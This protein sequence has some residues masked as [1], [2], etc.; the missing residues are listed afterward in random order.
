VELVV[1]AD[2]GFADPNLFAALER[3]GFFYIV[4]LR[5]NARLLCKVERIAK[6]RP[7]RPCE[8]RSVF[9]RFAFSYRSKGWK[10]S[11][12]VLARAEFEP[13][14]L[15]PDWTFLCAHLPTKER[16]RRV[17]RA[18]FGRGTS[19]Q[20]NDVF[21]NELRGDLMSHR[22]LRRNQVRGLLTALAQNLLVAFDH[23]T[24][25]NR[26]RR[27]PNTIRSRVLLVATSILRHARRLVL[28]LS[29]VGPRAVALVR[30]AAALRDLGPTRL[31]SA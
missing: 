21:K 3:H 22:R 30:T 4:R 12:R 14:T 19:E 8:D 15:F 11:R 29:A 13:G 25:P 9:R 20:V 5:E 17:S 7:G 31:S 23:A 2:S 16:H 24:R 28:R 26:R 6:R 1:R 18:Y 27:R 10:T